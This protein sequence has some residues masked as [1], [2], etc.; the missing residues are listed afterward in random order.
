LPATILYVH[1]SDEMYGAD[2]ILLQLVEHLDRQRF[3]PLVVLPTD[4]PHPGQLTDALAQRRIDTIHLPTAVLRRKYFT[5]LG[6]LVYS[7]RLVVST[8]ALIRIIRSE[9]VKI[10][11][12]NTTAVVP[13]A[14]AARV[15]HTPHIWHV[16]EIITKPRILWRLTAWLLPRLSA[17]VV[18]V[19]TPVR[20]HLC[21][22]DRRNADKSIVIHNGIDAM[23]FANVGGEDVRREWSLE[24]GDSLIGMVGRVSHWKGQDYFLQVAQR[25]V[26]REP[27]ARFALVGS[28][29]PG[30]ERMMKEL[31]HSVENLHLSTSV[32]VAGFRSD[33]PSVLA[34]LDVFVLPSILPD[35]FPTVILEAMA[36]GKPVVANAHGGSIEMVEDGTTG[37]LIPPDQPEE[38]ATAIVRLLADP[39][40]RR[41]M[42]NCG[43]ERCISKFS[44]DAFLR[45]WQ[46]IYASMLS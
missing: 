41:R 16:H 42:G 15:T 40:E 31:Q 27:H 28:T 20:D 3:R 35:P 45:T 18:A 29:F 32:I 37:Y 46:T 23:R 17:R 26:A 6:I 34:A 2:F 11:H 7:W 44:L 36:S 12:S 19:S 1:A 33:I 8:L 24:P 39:E 43:R 13:G 10:V 9:R 5:P 4:V 22:G 38:M 14:L 25:V 30:Q 21:A